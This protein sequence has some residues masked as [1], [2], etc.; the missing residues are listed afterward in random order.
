MKSIRSFKKII[1]QFSQKN[2]H[3]QNQFV[4]GMFVSLLNGK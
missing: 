4:V 1:T 2:N 3:A